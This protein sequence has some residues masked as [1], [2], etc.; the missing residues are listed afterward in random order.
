MGPANFRVFTYFF[1][2]YID[3]HQSAKAHI[4]EMH[5]RFIIFGTT[6]LCFLFCGCRRSTDDKLI[7]QWEAS[8]GT[9]DVGMATAIVTYG[10]DHT[11]LASVQTDVAGTTTGT[12]C[13]E[14]DQ[15]ITKVKSST[16]KKAN[17]GKEFRQTIVHLE[18]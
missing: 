12:W 15:I 14:G 7:G 1:D 3:R 4:A 13:V 6:F 10:K 17:E 11:V 8:F 18:K 2:D 9:A 5:C 16:V